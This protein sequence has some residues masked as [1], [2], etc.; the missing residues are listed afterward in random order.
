MSD[1]A[2][3]NLDIENHGVKS[4][5]WAAPAGL[6]AIARDALVKAVARVP[7]AW[8]LSPE[9]KEL[10]NTPEEVYSRL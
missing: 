7:P 9:D 2:V 4:S 1:L 10:F 5:F 8:L 6:T 3:A